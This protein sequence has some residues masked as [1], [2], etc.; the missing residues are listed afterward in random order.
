MMM[1]LRP[2]QRLFRSN[3]TG[4]PA[5]L[6]SMVRFSKTSGNFRGLSQE[7]LSAGVSFPLSG[8]TS[9]V[10]PRIPRTETPTPLSMGELPATA[11]ACHSSPRT[12]TYPEGASRSSAM[13]CAPIIESDS[14]LRFRSYARHTKGNRITSLAIQ[15][16]IPP[17]KSHWGSSIQRCT[18]IR[19]RARATN[20]GSWK[21]AY[22]KRI[23]A[24]HRRSAMSPPFPSFYKFT[25][26][27][28]RPKY[29]IY[30]ING[31]GKWL[32]VYI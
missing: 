20:E 10:S 1:G 30:P 11:S 31:D 22:R 21:S 17:H 29:Q 23:R 19:M 5:T 18:S 8:F 15:R 26:G 32:Y 9:R 25:T 13:P 27:F 7:G 12:R 14:L 3:V 28:R 6:G 24:D 4:I 2:S 16:A